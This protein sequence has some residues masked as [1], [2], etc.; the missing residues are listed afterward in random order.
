MFLSEIKLSIELQIDFS[1][2][3]SNIIAVSPA[4]SERELVLLPAT[5][6]LAE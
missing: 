3:G 4:T 6:Y 2:S 1:L 5:V